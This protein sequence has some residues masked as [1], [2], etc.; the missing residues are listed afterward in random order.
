MAKVPIMN[1]PLHSA[2][3][4]HDMA[5]PE[6][7]WI[8]TPAGR[9]WLRDSASALIFGVD[10]TIN[11]GERVTV[12]AADFISEFAQRAAELMAED[13]GFRLEWALA[14]GNAL[15]GGKKY[16]DLAREVA[17]QMLLPHRDK[18]EQAM[19]WLED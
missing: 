18:A 10:V 11:Y 5:E 4:R 8:E 6:V 19:K 12:R 16:Q 9:N 3:F 17:E 2:Q 14:R 1:K 15:V 7:P 13:A